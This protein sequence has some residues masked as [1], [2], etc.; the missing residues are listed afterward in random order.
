[1]VAQ[2]T[3]DNSQKKYIASILDRMTSEKPIVAPGRYEDYK[4]PLT[5]E[6]LKRWIPSDENKMYQ[7]LLSDKTPVN[8][9]FAG[10]EVSLER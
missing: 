7:A 6:K 8:V 9:N 3:E 10:K 1:M 2:L 5:G 4:A